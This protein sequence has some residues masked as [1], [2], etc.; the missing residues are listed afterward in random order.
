MAAVTAWNR[1]KDLS[2]FQMLNPMGANL[3]YFGVAAT[4]AMSGALM[5][6]RYRAEYK[7]SG[8]TVKPYDA[9]KI[10]SNTNYWQLADQIRNFSYLGIGGVLALTSLMATFGV[11]VGLNAQAWMWLGLI[12]TLTD[13]V[14]GLIRFLGY[15]KAYS[16]S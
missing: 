3:A 11:A 2:T 1:V 7:V 12:G 10:G 5:A 14:V 16:D 15:D 4:F 8:T 6:F 13:T 9:G